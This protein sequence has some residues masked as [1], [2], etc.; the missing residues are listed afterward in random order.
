MGRQSRLAAIRQEYQVLDSLTLCRVS[1]MP[2]TMQPI[3]RVLSRL[4]WDP[5]YRHGRYAIGY[6]DRVLRRIV[7]VPFEQ[8]SFPLAARKQFEIW[9]GNGKRIRVPLHRV[10]RIYR[11]GRV[12][13]ERNPPGE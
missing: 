6:F 10:R 1:A 3:H 4:R 13:W 12:L 7:V 11:D 8:I 9:D 5:R 2:N